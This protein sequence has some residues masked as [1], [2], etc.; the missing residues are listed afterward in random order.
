MAPIWEE[1]GHKIKEGVNIG[2]VD[3]TVHKSTNY[4]LFHCLTHH[5]DACKKFQVQ[6]YPTIMFINGDFK[7]NYS[8]ARSLNALEEFAQKQVNRPP[9]KI[10]EAAGIQ[11]IYEENP[12]VLIFTYDGLADESI[13]NPMVSTIYE[14][15]KSIKGKI[16]VYFW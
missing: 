2:S 6:G 3:C 16:P 14:V 9:F 5:L 1:L 4:K 10:I 11:K 15:A 7:E 8:G 12:S 13:V